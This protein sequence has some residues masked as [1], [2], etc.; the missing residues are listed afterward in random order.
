MMELKG[1]LSFVDASLSIFV[2]E[3]QNRRDTYKNQHQHVLL[4]LLSEDTAIAEPIKGQ[5]TL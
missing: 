5:L 4:G 2:D 1:R 3:E